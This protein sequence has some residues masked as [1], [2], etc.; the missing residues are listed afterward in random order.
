MSVAG[1]AA[2]SGVT[3]ILQAV[4]AGLAALPGVV[5]AW[6]GAV[7]AVIQGA[8]GQAVG[9]VAN[10]CGQIVQTM[11][12]YAGA[13]E[14]SGVAIGA[15][16]A[17]GL[18]STTRLVIGAATAL[19]TAAR[20]VFPNS[21][22]KEGPFS[23]SGWV[24]KSGESVGQAFA[25]GM[26]DSSG[27]VVSTARELMQAIKDV[28]GDSKN[29]ELN[30]NFGAGGGLAAGVPSFSSGL[31]GL[32]SSFDSLTPSVEGFQ[33]QVDAA[34]GALTNLNPAES[35]ARIKELTQSL[36]E[37]EIQRKTAEAAR[38]APGA[39]QTAI[40]AQL[41]QIRNQ[42][43]LLGLERDKLNYA[44]KYGG[45]VDDTKNGYGDLVKKASEMPVDFGKAV[46]GQFMSDLG[47][48]GGGL[49]TQALDY[50]T[51]FVFNVSNMDDALAGQRSLQN[52]Q[53]LTTLGR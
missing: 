32:Q 50:G 18:A 31:S 47:F 27:G 12:S 35:K 4:Q 38:N 29:I 37:L 52:K 11:L 10:V 2:A 3:T 8:M 16:F 44:A 25:Q 34:G 21:P 42:K 45:V 7:P 15:S 53:S 46:G 9:T 23:G 13:A 6:F 26:R 1:Q 5:Q 41:E 19:M 17:K 51:Q 48:S 40:K 22:A 20:P 30:F 14:Q 28:F 33:Q 49:L 39:D 24:D 43:N 36:A